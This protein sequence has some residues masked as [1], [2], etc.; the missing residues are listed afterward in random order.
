VIHAVK[1]TEQYGADVLR[2][3]VLSMDYAD[4]VRMSERGIKEASEA[5][6]KIRNTFRFI[7]GNLGDYADFDPASVDLKS[8]HAIDRWM[9]GQL[10]GVI[11]EVTESLER[12]EFYK[13]YQRIY[14]FCAG[15]LSSVYLD[16]LKDRLYAE[17]PGGAHRQAAQYV[18]SRLHH[19]L[20]ILL[21]PFIPHTTE[22]IW[23]YVPES[24]GRPAS[25]HLADW[26]QPDT[27]WD[28][29]ALAATFAKLLGIREQAF[30]AIEALRKAKTVGSNQEARLMVYVDRSDLAELAEH[31]ELLTTLCV[32]S[33]V[34]VCEESETG[35]G[36][37]ADRASNPKCERCWNLRATVGSNPK[38][39]TLCDR[40]VGVIQEIGLPGA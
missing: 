5:Y 40:C 15:T 29:A 4:D 38:F 22:E 28:N 1:A 21:A 37:V 30:I 34:D 13:A 39:P 17:R 18:L 8:L 9:L 35:R 26:P 27:R 32:V 11:R 14:Q 31:K 20:A 7:L 2:L 33:E 16:V 24:A 12:F 23:E 6:R 36:V 19:D 25:V 3:Y 10:N